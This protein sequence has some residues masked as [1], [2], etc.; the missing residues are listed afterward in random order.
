VAARRVRGLIGVAAAVACVGG[1]LASTPS[2]SAGS[3]R[4]HFAK[5]AVPRDVRF[6]QVRHSLLGEHTWYQQTVKGVPVYG[7]WYGVHAFNNGK[8][9]IADERAKLR[10]FKLPVATVPRA[11]AAK[12]AIATAAKRSL[13]GQ[14]ARAIQL[15]VLPNATGP[16]A[17]LSWLVT[18]L[19]GGTE[20][21]TFVD[22]TKGAVL[23]QVVSSE[24][25]TGRG[26]VFNPNPVVSLQ[27]ESLRDHADANSAVPQTAYSTVTLANLNANTNKLIG[28]WARIVNSNGASSSTGSF[29]YNRHDDR[30]EQVNAYYAV[31]R[32][33][34]Y[35]RSLGITDANASSQK[36]RTDAF[37]DDNS[38]Y[39]SFNDE[40]DFGWG[41][42]DDA[43]DQEV[44]WHEYG[45]AVQDDQIPGF[46]LGH[47]AGSIGEGWG[48]YLAFTMSQANSPS[49]PTTPLACIADWD[50]ISYTSGTPHCL[51]RVDTNLTVNN[52]NGEVHHD[53]QIWSG[54]LFDI[55]KALGRDRANRVILEAQFNWSP[56]EQFFDGATEI[57]NEAQNLYGTTAANQV[58]TAFHA[59]GIL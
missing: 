12:L 54:A 24:H 58:Q 52:E 36:L 31:D 25:K 13:G 55:N 40:I 41:G 48:D 34:T 11:S 53:G 14:A 7:G 50:S 57:K 47:D 4:P 17:R 6:V 44:V 51:R 3:T 42:V 21:R 23:K 27:N 9:R 32:V 19:S 39:T 29:L 15:Y 26:K 22:A 37:A 28:R 2:A 38:Q 30:F 49:S 43:E 46:G 1:V 8:V 59:R 5:V 45:H 18:S 20:V 16:R 35:F 10:G 33:Q 56:D